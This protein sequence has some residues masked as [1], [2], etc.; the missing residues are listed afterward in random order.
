MSR[1]R[2]IRS[3][4]FTGGLSYGVSALI[5]V[6]LVPFLLARLGP[7]RY[8]LVPLANSFVQ[9]LSL[10][11]IGVNY[12]VGRLV[13]V[14][15]RRAEWDAAR[16]TYSTAVTLG[17]GFA[18]LALVI[19]STITWRLPDLIRIPSGAVEESRLLFGAVFLS[20][21]LTSWGTPI[22]VA[23]YCSERLDLRHWIELSAKVFRALLIVLLFGLVGAQA[24]F[25]GLGNLA[26]AVILL[27]GA[28]WLRQHLLPQL[29]WS[30]R[31]WSVSSARE[32]LSVGQW[33]VINN[34]GSLLFLHVDLIVINRL[35]GPTATGEYG[36]LLQ[37]VV[38]LRGLAT[39]I[40]GSFAPSVLNAFAARD[41]QT[42]VR[43]LESSMKVVAFVVGLPAIVLA[44]SAEHFLTLWLGPEHT[45]LRWVLVVL[46]AHLA[47][48]QVALALFP[49]H[50]AFDRLR[51]PAILTVLMGLA[52]VGALVLLAERFGLVGAAV[53]G[54]VSLAVK[55][56][57]LL[58]IYTGRVVSGR[59][60]E[61]AGAMARVVL[62]AVVLGTVGAVVFARLDNLTV[63]GFVVVVAVCVAVDLLLVRT[64]LM[65]R[66]E[67][68]YVVR[69][70]RSAVFG[71]C[72]KKDGGQ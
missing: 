68:D 33:A 59:S 39:M 4:L 45:H 61:F 65:N 36:A 52:N 8:G 40:S 22:G 31:S 21:A 25:V 48:T 19:G 38:I 28:F 54:A 3:A 35:L 41:H 43:L 42:T 60:F 1:G 57:F 69:S 71:A 30:H 5:G 72:G 15:V 29:R 58:P 56:L 27:V 10:I 46:V 14:P 17:A 70:V 12:S 55:N 16:S 26:L 24:W 20:F 49:A 67:W 50:L 44:V 63:P 6:W 7:E 23:A 32:L 53:A 13:C 34:V 9:Y 47:V 66:T 11:V 2:R 18:I 62:R 37:L 64:V 51:A